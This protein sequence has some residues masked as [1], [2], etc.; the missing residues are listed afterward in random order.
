MIDF[1]TQLLKLTLFPTLVIGSIVT[2]LFT[3]FKEAKWGLFLLVFLIPQPNVWHKFYEHPLGNDLLDFVYFAILLGIFFQRKGFALT[4]NGWFII[5]FILVSYLSLWNSSTRFSLPLPI[6]SSS[7]MFMDWKNYAQMIFLYYLVLNVV[8]DEKQQKVLV[9][10]MSIVLLIIA[11][12]CYRNFY[13]GDIFSWERR[14]VGPFVHVN[15]GPNE[16]SAFVVYCW[17]FF[18]GLLFFEKIRWKKWLFFATIL[19]MLHPIFFTFSRGGYFAAFIVLIFFGVVK[20]RSLLILTI[21]LFFTWQVVLPK[22]VVDRIEMTQTEEGELERSAGGRLGLWDLGLEI[23]SENPIFGVGYQGYR[24]SVGGKT[25]YQGEEIKAGGADPH[26][27]YVLTLS[28][29]GVIGIIMFLCILFASFRSG[30]KLY[31]IAKNPFNKG[32]ALGFMGAVVALIIANMFGDRWSYF[33]LGS[34]FWIFWGL[35]DR[36][37]LLSQKNDLHAGRQLISN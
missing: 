15:L 9:I 3:I 29:Q 10:I 32:L 35:V 19:F 13:V 33:V 4:R 23:F 8:K 37:I 17:A 2:I 20:K 34:Y 28:E 6:S 7:Q 11:V 18:T 5:L 25:T 14:V 27:Y 31:K 21:V 12:R 22:T 1:I 16:F 30:L 24:M 26:N 36:G